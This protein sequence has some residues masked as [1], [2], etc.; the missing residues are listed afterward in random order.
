MIGVQLSLTASG[1]V[2]GNLTVPVRLRYQACDA[3]MCYPP[4]TA[5]VTWVI[6]VVPA[7]ATAAP[8]AGAGER[9]RG[10]QVRDG[11][12]T[13]RARLGSPER[14]ATRLAEA[15]RS[16]GRRCGAARR[17]HDRR[18]DRRVP[19]HVRL[20]L[21]HSRR[22]SRGQAARSVRGPRPA[23]HPASRPARRP[24]AQPDAVRPADDPDQPGDHRRRRAGA[25]ARPGFPARHGLRRRDGGRLRH[26]RA[27]RHPH[28]R[29]VRH[30]QLV[31]VVQPRHRDPVRRARPRDVRRPLHRLLEVLDTLCRRRPARKRD[32]GVHAWAR[33]RRC[34][35]APASRRS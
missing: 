31:A 33:S 26:P 4:T 32:A 19:G 28:R 8:N 25:V 3:K 2:A 27:R 11:R 20:S 23:R 6:T 12:E 34:W 1:R 30:D 16:C 17:L 15:R 24:R 22:G 29:H 21:V 35:P 13:S 5:D 7:S 10:H 18:H 9:V 14:G